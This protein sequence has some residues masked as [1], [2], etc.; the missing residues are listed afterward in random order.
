M[1]LRQV[2]YIWG[3]FYWDQSYLGWGP[4]CYYG[5][6]VRVIYNATNTWT[7]IFKKGDVQET[8]V[9]NGTTQIYDMYGNLLDE[10][11][12]TVMERLFDAGWM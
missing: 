3:E 11:A 6:D 4:A 8:L 7:Y 9:Q 10:R 12:F 2:N 5:Q 1:V